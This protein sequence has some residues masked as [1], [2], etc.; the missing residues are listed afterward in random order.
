MLL[1]YF[2]LLTSSHIYA[3]LY[4]LPP[5]HGIPALAEQVISNYCM[6]GSHNISSW[7]LCLGRL[8]KAQAHLSDLIPGTTV[9]SEEGVGGFPSQ[10]NSHRDNECFPGLFGNCYQPV[11]N[12]GGFCAVRG[13]AFAGVA[14][15]GLHCLKFIRKDLGWEAP[16]FWS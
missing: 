9:N 15:A 13:K 4:L 12:L 2:D 14:M 6:A 3:F 1:Y 8:P 10:R 16:R 7:V 11:T 5:R